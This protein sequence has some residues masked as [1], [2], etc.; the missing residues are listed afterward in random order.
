MCICTLI[1]ILDF[2]KMTN[3]PNLY[4]NVKC[5]MLNIIWLVSSKV[6]KSKCV[7]IAKTFRVPISQIKKF[8]IKFQGF[9]HQPKTDPGHRW[10]L[11]A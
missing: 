5:N 9:L 8:T 1:N 10:K 4:Q 6:L 3:F 7:R 11:N 2:I